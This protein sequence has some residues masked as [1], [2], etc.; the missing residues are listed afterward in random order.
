M[1]IFSLSGV[2]TDG[3]AADRRTLA[4]SEVTSMAEVLSNLDC[5]RDVVMDIVLASDI[6]PHVNAKRQAMGQAGDLPY[7]SG[8]ISGRA[9]GIVLFGNDGEAILVSIIL[10]NDRWLTD[11]TENV[12]LRWFL[13]LHELMHV[14]Q[15]ATGVGANHE[16]F[17]E[18]TSTYRENVAYQARKAFDEYDADRRADQLS[19]RFLRAFGVDAGASNFFLNG[20]AGSTATLLAA[21]GDFVRTEVLPHRIG[22]GDEFALGLNAHK[23]VRE[24]FKVLPHAAALADAVD[25]MDGLTEALVP[26]SGFSTYLSPDWSAFVKAMRASSGTEAEPELSRIW[27]DVLARLG[28]SITNGDDGRLDIQVSEP[29]LP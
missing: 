13:L 15:R 29:L 4:E 7:T 3:L 20:Y 22:G 2:V 11:E 27:T 24:L 5:E 10:Q 16:D 23:L 17:D 1:S 21:M 6:A 26:Q 18:A 14:M 12:V 9:E 25:A 28:L 19:R 8:G